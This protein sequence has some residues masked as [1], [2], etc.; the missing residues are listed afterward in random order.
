MS[1]QEERNA[2]KKARRKFRHE[3]LKRMEKVAMR[4]GRCFMTDAQIAAGARILTDRYMHQ[5]DHAPARVELAP[6]AIP[7]RASASPAS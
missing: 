3:I 4:R 6:A 2:A 1:S 5:V 7:E